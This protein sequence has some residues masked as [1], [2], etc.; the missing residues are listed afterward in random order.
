MSV[1]ESEL[2]AAVLEAAGE[3]RAATGKSAWAAFEAPEEVSENGEVL[4]ALGF[5]EGAAMALNLTP[6]ELLDQLGVAD[7]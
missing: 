1:S 2:R 5:V 3:I 7:D 6:L 4:R